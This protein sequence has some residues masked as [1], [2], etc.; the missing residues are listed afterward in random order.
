MDLR[1][2]EARAVEEKET[3]EREMREKEAKL[4]ILENDQSQMLVK[5]KKLSDHVVEMG[6]S[7][8]TCTKQRDELLVQLEVVKAQVS[9]VVKFKGNVTVCKDLKFLF[10]TKNSFCHE[11]AARL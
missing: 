10:V 3:L 9:E 4:A 8:E 6:L 1:E 5:F 7:L 11:F 2:R